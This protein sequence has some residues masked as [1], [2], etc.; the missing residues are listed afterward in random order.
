MKLIIDIESGNSACRTREDVLQILDTVRDKLR[1][2]GT[3]SKHKILDANGQSVGYYSISQDDPDEDEESSDDS[4]LDDVLGWERAEMR[5]MSVPDPRAITMR[6]FTDR[7]GASNYEVV[8]YIHSSGDVGVAVYVNT[9]DD[10]FKVGHA[11][12]P[13]PIDSSV[14]REGGYI[15]YPK[16]DE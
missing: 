2:A 15:V 8:P 11:V 13:M 5:E 9:W 4:G 6:E 16:Y 7:A 3:D 12:Y 14:D 1:L 10:V